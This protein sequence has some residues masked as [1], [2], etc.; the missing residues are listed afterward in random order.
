MAASLVE[1]GVRRGDRVGILLP[2]QP[3]AIAAVYGVMKTGAAY[4]PLDPRAPE[5]YTAVICSDCDPSALITTRSRATG[6]LD[7]LEARRASPP[8]GVV[9]VDEARGGSDHLQV[10]SISYSEAAAPPGAPS[11]RGTRGDLACLLYTSG[12]TGAP[13]GVMH[14][15][16]AL[17]AG[18][19]WFCRTMGVGPDDRLYAHAPLHFM[20][21]VYGVFPAAL[22]SATSVLS[23]IEQPLPSDLAQL[24][25]AE[26]VTVW[27][28]TP[29]PLRLLMAGAKRRSLASLRTVMCGGGS[30][31]G[32]DVGTLRSLG[33]DA[34][35]WHSYGSTEALAVC[36]HLVEDVP[37][38]SRPVAIGEPID[39]VTVLLV[40][41]GDRAGQP[42][43][44]GELYVGSP[45]LMQGY[46][47]DPERT[48]QVLVPHPSQ[49]GGRLFRTGDVVRWLGDGKLEYVKRTDLTVKVRGY[50]V[51]LNEVEAVLNGHPAT[52]ESVVVAAPH[53]HWGVTIVA[54]L[55]LRDGARATERQLRGHVAA[56][57]PSYMVPARIV[58]MSKLPRTSTDKVD[59]QRLA[60]EL[61]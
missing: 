61:P 2:K 15:H 32:S 21:S 5:A 6:V 8:R 59:R 44:E 56:R 17:L 9:M 20:L 52:R 29:F 22:R 14:T 53:P 50:R 40:G 24:V 35:V 26:G 4:V 58:T 19:R 60:A 47:G 12:S 46:W 23:M 42:V 25:S 43:Q 1:L 30:L 45:R 38:A 28:S 48:A 49:E 3:E 36:C 16:D 51:D 54:Y 33:S 31:L 7:V 13:K 39:D 11:V 10:P 57:L 34:R 18:T 41:D 27:V 55:E 37:D